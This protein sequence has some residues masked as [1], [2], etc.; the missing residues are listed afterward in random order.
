MFK[1]DSV[2]H[3]VFY[4]TSS[5]S[6]GKSFCLS[7]APQFKILPSALDFWRCTYLVGIYQY[8]HSRIIAGVC[9]MATALVSF[10]FTLSLSEIPQAPACSPF[11]P[12]HLYK[13]LQMVSL[14]PL[15]VTSVKDN[16]T[17]FAFLSLWV[18][19]G[20]NYHSS[21]TTLSKKRK[22]SLSFF[23]LKTFTLW[24]IFN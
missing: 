18:E 3:G 16:V 5:Y 22:I 21:S 4:C 23:N 6:G 13:G 1:F 17:T 11:T 2:S 15:C 9:V 19:E 14:N 10:S 7:L 8:I 24:W 20:K 12:E